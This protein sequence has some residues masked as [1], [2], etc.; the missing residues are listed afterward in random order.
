MSKTNYLLGVISLAFFI[1][2]I[3]SFSSAEKKTPLEIIQNPEI[4]SS[5]PEVELKNP[6]GKKMKLSSLQGK[7]VLLDFW[8]SWCKPCRDENPNLVSAYE[9]YTGATLKSGKGFEI[10]S[11]SLDKTKE[12]WIKAIKSDKLKWKYHV[13]DLKGWQSDAA[14]TY[15]VKSIPTNFLINPEGKIVAT[16]LRGMALHV[17]MD[18]NVEKF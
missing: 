7:W 1:A 13:S 11:V 10:F 14:A 17:E 2:G 4:G 15:K 18:K 9:K 8:A 5:A 16:N 12:P 3:V 6:S